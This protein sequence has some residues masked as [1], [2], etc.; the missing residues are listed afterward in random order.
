ML[1]LVPL[2]PEALQLPVAV[3]VTARFEEA[4]ALTVNAE[5]P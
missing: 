4:E 2:A 1:M 3:N 5:S